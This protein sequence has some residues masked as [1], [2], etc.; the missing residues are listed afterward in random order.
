V[1]ISRAIRCLGSDC[2]E[3][4]KLVSVQKKNRI[5]YVRKGFLGIMYVVV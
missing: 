1:V 5:Y 4:M 3:C 2:V